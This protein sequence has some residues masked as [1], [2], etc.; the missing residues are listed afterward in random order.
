MTAE[1]VY[2]L[3][4]RVY[5]SD[6]RSEYGR[7]MMLIFRDEYRMRDAAALTFWVSMLWDVAHSAMSIWAD[8]WFAEENQ[9]T[10]IEG[11]IMKVAGI[12]AVSL[13]VFGAL[14]AVVE[15][16]A[17]RGTLERPPLWGVVLGGVAGVLLIA[18]GSVVV[19]STRSARSTATVT[20]VASLLIILIVRL[21]HPWMS[22]LS[23]LIG[24]GLPIALLAALHWPRRH[25]DSSASPA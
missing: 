19:R 5:P 12:M 21:T 1:R 23:E 24:I 9:Y 14:N 8:V 20:L 2:G 25:D 16:V 18:A 17:M 6:F 4:L 3:L 10:Q 7:E 15:G 22:E 13:G 11:V